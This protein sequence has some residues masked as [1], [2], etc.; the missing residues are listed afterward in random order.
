MT[1]AEIT[2]QSDDD[3]CTQN[4]KMGLR[5]HASH[6]LIAP[7][8]Q[9]AELVA[10]GEAAMP[11]PTK[12]GPYKSSSS[13]ASRSAAPAAQAIGAPDTCVRCAPHNRPQP[14]RRTLNEKKAVWAVTA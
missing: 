10:M 1:K 9:Q 13:Y 6:F 4:Y 7:A 2:Q 5:S 3:Y 8:G 11:Q 14:K 12:R